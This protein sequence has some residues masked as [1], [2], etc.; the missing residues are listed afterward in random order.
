MSTRAGTGS[1]ADA[2]R[3]RQ[4]ALNAA[5]ALL[6]RPD[7]AL[8][9][10]VIAKEAGLGAATVVRAFGGKDALLDRSSGAPAICS[11]RPRPTRPC[12]PS[13]AS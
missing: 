12:T 5:M 2:V 9:V 7:A 4:L 10:E 13:S 1:R 6:A 8:T 3:N 11:P